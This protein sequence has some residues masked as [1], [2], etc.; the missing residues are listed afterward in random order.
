MRFHFLNEKLSHQISIPSVT[1]ID[2]PPQI[3]IINYSHDYLILPTTNSSNPRLVWYKIHL[4]KWLIWTE[5]I[6]LCYVR[7]DSI[8]RNVWTYRS[9]C[10]RQVRLYLDQAVQLLVFRPVRLYLDRSDLVLDH[11]YD[12]MCPYPRHTPVTN[13]VIYILVGGLVHP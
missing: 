1:R 12:W 7:T 9:D 2:S 5:S 3:N 11:V 8:A 13:H 6:I 4:L 10:L